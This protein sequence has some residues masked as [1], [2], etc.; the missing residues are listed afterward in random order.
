MIKWNL[1]QR[2][3]E[4]MD[5]YKKVVLKNANK[6]KK[7]KEL[8]ELLHLDPSDQ[9]ILKRKMHD[10]LKE[11]IR[12]LKSDE[13]YE[14]FSKIYHEN[15][16]KAR[17]LHKSTNNYDN[18]E[19]QI[20]TS[21]RDFR[22]VKRLFFEGT[23][24]EWNERVDS[25]NLTLE[26]KNE[27]K[28]SMSETK[29]F[30]NKLAPELKEK[31]MKIVDKMCNNKKYFKEQMD[32]VTKELRRL[33]LWDQV[34]CI[35]GWLVSLPAASIMIVWLFIMLGSGW[36]NEHDL[37]GNLYFQEA[38][39]S[40]LLAWF[41]VVWAWGGV[42]WLWILAWKSVWS[43]IDKPRARKLLEKYNEQENKWIE[44]NLEK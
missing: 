39:L 28:K 19:D 21:A 4:Y 30:I 23:S 36:W 8:I 6:R 7:E 43:K 15:I 13:N 37:N 26:Q 14:F 24:K 1:D 22:E 3:K 9:E 27:I 33:D 10:S 25:S 11:S 35:I 20:N 5:Q 41:G 44:D 40:W 2:S 38:D 16:Q 32:L 18:H 31:M 29:K 12:L 17:L 42:W 34:A